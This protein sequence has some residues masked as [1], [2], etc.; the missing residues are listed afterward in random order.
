MATLDDLKSVLESI[1]RTMIDQKTLL[2]NM[3]AAQ[4]TSAR[5]S[6]VNTS[7]ANQTQP[8]TGQSV[9]AAAAGIGSGVGSAAVGLGV[10]GLAALAG[11]AMFADFDA[12][13]IKDNVVTLLSISDEVGGK[14][15]MLKEGGT[16]FLAMTGLAVGLAAFGIGQGLVGLGQWITDDQWTQTLKTN[17]V[18]LLSIADEVGGK[19]EMLKEGGTFFLAMSG[20]G[21]GLAAF[22]IGQG[23][24]GLGQWITDTDWAEQVKA[25]VLT[26]LSIGDEIG[27]LD[28]LYAGG[29][30]PLAM[31]GLGVGLA[32]FGVG[33]AAVGLAQ[34]ISTD[35]WAQKVKDNVVTLLSISELDGVGWNTVGFIGVM[36]GIATGLAAFALGKGG[37][38][39]VDGAAEALGYFTGDSFADKIKSEVETLLSIPQ[40][41]GVAADTAGFIAVMAGIS[42]GLAAFALG[43]GAATVV[44]GAAE[45]LAYFT[46]DDPFAEKI[47]SEV[48]T[49]LSIVGLAP[50]GSVDEFTNIM[51]KLGDGLSSFAGG[52]FVGALKNVGTALLGFFS[53][54]DS[55]FEQI[56]MIASDADNLVKAADAIEKIANSLEKFG[57]IDISVGDIDFA[58]LAENLGESLPLLDKLANG[59]IYDPWGLGNKIDFGEKGILDSSLKLDEMAEAISKVNYVLGQTTEY[60][61]SM[62]ESAAAATAESPV[63][64][65]NTSQTAAILTA[66]TDKMIELSQN[67]LKSLDVIQSAVPQN[68]QQTPASFYANNGNTDAR[69][70]STSI[71]INNNQSQKDYSELKYTSFTY[72]K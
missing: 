47:K 1:D 48:E 66:Q 70:T 2:T 8:S 62:Q 24:V 44:D 65:N 19:S 16:F 61:V 35:D 20:L 53:G 52:N 9:G 28:A 21:I 5:L 50:E 36:G 4:A 7:I 42:T 31:T 27:V 22:G 14:A 26:L 17:V 39:V 57:S 49:L 69:Q 34:F 13:A 18:D 32:V 30:F 45:A 23:L 29:A 58:K 46:G 11:M 41:E 68:T 63:A 15:E 51:S 43:K 64:T 56:R 3:V 54:Q 25:N 33:Q 72:G 6:S 37:A 59:G 67:I 38:V 60:P 71:N 40:M 55:P 10:G 12:Q